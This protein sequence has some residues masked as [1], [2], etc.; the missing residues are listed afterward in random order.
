M[1][2]IKKPYKWSGFHNGTPLPDISFTG[3]IGLKGRSS[4]SAEEG[5]KFIF[6]EK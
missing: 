6:W 1:E 5:K 3:K 2:G 4:Y